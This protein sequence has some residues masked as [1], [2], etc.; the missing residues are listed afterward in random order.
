MAAIYDD[1]LNQYAEDT[2]K[3]FEHYLELVKCDQISW[4]T[5]VANI[6][7][8]I[9]TYSQSKQLIR[10]LLTEL[11]FLLQNAKE[12][13]ETLQKLEIFEFH[14]FKPKTYQRKSN[15]KI[16]DV[17]DITSENPLLC[18]LCHK[19]F[20]YRIAYE[21]HLKIHEIL[22]SSC[23]TT[24][25]E[26]PKKVKNE[27]VSKIPRLTILYQEQDITGKVEISDLNECFINQSQ[28]NL[29]ANYEIVPNLEEITEVK[30]VPECDISN[31]D[32]HENDLKTESE[33]DSLEEIIDH[34]FDDPTDNSSE[35]NSYFGKHGRSTEDSDEDFSEI[36]LKIVKKL[37]FNK[38]IKVGFDD[39]LKE[40]DTNPGIDGSEKALDKDSRFDYLKTVKKKPNHDKIR[41]VRSD[42]ITNYSNE[43]Y[44]SNSGQKGPIKSEILNE[45]ISETDFKTG[46]ESPYF[47]EINDNPNE[48]YKYV[49]EESLEFGIKTDLKKEPIFDTISK[50]ESDHPTQSSSDID[51]KTPRKK[52]KTMSVGKKSTKNK[53]YKKNFKNAV[54]CQLCEHTNYLSSKW[55][56]RS[57]YISKHN[58]PK[59]EAVERTKHLKFEPDKKQVCD[60]CDKRYKTFPELEKHKIS[61]TGERPYECDFCEKTFNLKY[62]LLQH[63]KLHLDKKRY[64]C[65]QCGKNYPTTSSLNRHFASHGEKKFS[66][67]HCKKA[68]TIKKSLEIHMKIHSNE[69]HFKCNTCSKRFIQLCSLKS[70]ERTH[71]GEKPFECQTCNKRFRQSSALI[72]H[73]IVHASAKPYKCDTC[74]KSFKR[75]SVLKKHE[76]THTDQMP[77]KCNQCT[78]SFRTLTNLRAH[79]K[80]HSGLKTFKC[81]ICAKGFSR[82]VSLK[83]HEKTH[84]DNL[85]LDWSK[86]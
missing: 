58:L 74:G 2:Q 78:K 26:K 86:E 51:S 84:S 10:I 70:H 9:P 43:N 19:T 52:Q 35:N 53:K 25:S 46:K 56:L 76:F 3:N 16:H 63:Q 57:H 34:D 47:N 32:A 37:D 15:S 13:M 55:Y 41:E 28:M 62:T 40:N 67:E 27:S 69:R 66:C 48:N 1:F 42:G 71:S 50:F 30:L 39:N 64:T 22:N 20:D 54:K 36:D 14:K 75:N 60:I 7:D 61:H 83:L 33:N 8:L 23:G 5:F 82:K 59:V 4:E 44:D 49:K 77:H 68:F 65:E 17:I 18:N 12:E 79:E 73:E 85:H 29:E 6:E 11:K 45:N 81:V 72:S 38:I 31:K 80:V 21:K 24:P